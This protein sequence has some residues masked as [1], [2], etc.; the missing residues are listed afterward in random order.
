[1]VLSPAII[2]T[3]MWDVVGWNRAAALLLTDYAKLPHDGRNI[4]RLMFGSDQGR[5]RNA[6]WE[7][8]AR[9]V[10]G[11]FRADVA[12]AGANNSAAVTRLVI[13]LSRV[14]PEFE[15]LWQDNEVVAHGEGVKRLHHPDAGLL[16]IEFSSFAVEGR[17]ELGMII[18]NPASPADAERMRALLDARDD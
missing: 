4:L 18:Y 8:V 10:V 7:G 13:E 6:D 3:A 17:P 1:M 12:R 9:F 11:A 16:A 14:S 2:K 5:A 15:A